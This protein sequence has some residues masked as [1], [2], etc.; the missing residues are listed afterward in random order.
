M[1]H[2]LDVL[3]LKNKHRKGID[4]PTSSVLK[5]LGFCLWCGI[6]FRCVLPVSHSR[7]SMHCLSE[8]QVNSS[9][10]YSRPSRIHIS[11]SLMVSQYPRDAFVSP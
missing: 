11:F 3:Q 7:F 9:G 1:L 4:V 10:N 8:M 6:H 2:D 5:I